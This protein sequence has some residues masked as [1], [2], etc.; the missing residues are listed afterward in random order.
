MMFG[1]KQ[2]IIGGKKYM[3][4]GSTIVNENGAIRKAYSTTKGAVLVSGGIVKHP[5]G[6]KSPE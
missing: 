2:K 6:S 1:A 3:V 4:E 5:D